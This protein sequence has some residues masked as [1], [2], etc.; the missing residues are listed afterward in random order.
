MSENKINKVAD[1]LDHALR[2]LLVAIKPDPNISE[3]FNTAFL[4]VVAIPRAEMAME[5]Y[6]GLKE[7]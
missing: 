3:Y 5:A 7:K 1:D 4:N 2:T 6:K